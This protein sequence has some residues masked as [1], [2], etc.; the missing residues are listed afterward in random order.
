MTNI[1]CVIGAY[2]IKGLEELIAGDIEPAPE[3]V[4][5]CK[6]YSAD[7]ITFDDVGTGDPLLERILR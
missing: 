3:Y 7:L 6:D 1:G 4:V 5:F 2:S